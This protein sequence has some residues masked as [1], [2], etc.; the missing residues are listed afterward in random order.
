M[1]ISMSGL[2][3]RQRDAVSFHQTTTV[4]WCSSVWTLLMHLMAEAKCILYTR[5]SHSQRSIISICENKF[6]QKPHIT[7]NKTFGTHELNWFKKKT[8]KKN[9]EKKQRAE[10]VRITRSRFE[11]GQPLSEHMYTS[12]YIHAYE[13]NTYLKINNSKSGSAR[14][15]TCLDCISLCGQNIYIFQCMESVSGKKCMGFVL[16]CI[17][18]RCVSYEIQSEQARKEKNKI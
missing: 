5:Y 13:P 12:P 18:G 7:F 1:G 10:N 8:K 11:H 16:H 9:Q 14:R 17:V 15:V 3:L 2:S 6:S 4:G